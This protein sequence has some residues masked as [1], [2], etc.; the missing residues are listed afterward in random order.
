M[1]LINAF[2]YRQERYRPKITWRGLAILAKNC[3]RLKLAQLEFDAAE[4]DGWPA[5]GDIVPASDLQMLCLAWTRLDTD[6]YDAAARMIHQ[7]WPNANVGWG[8]WHG[9]QLER[10]DDDPDDIFNRFPDLSD[11]SYD[12]ALV[13]ARSIRRHL[14]SVRVADEAV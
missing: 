4:L 8:L 14:L 12:Q 9:G 2:E 3:P 1:T 7:I 10:P 11:E 5:R 6:D 13:V